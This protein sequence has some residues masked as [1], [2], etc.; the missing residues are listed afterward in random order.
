H[1]PFFEINRRFK[2]H[3]HASG[4]TGTDDVPRQKGHILADI[5]YQLRHIKNEIRS[6]AVLQHSIVEFK[7]KPQVMGIRYLIFGHQIGAKGS[8]IIRT[9]ALY[10]LPAMS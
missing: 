8:K 5:T 4:S 2:S 3:P 10:P 9:F 6:I 1:I 7:P